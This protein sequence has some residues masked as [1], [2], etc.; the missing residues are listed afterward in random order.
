MNQ[1]VMIPFPGRGHINPMLNLSHLL[2]S[3]INHPNRTTVFT[4][5]V[6]KEWLRLLNPD[7]NQPTVHFAT[8]PNVL[9][10]ELHRGS[11]MIAF[12]TAICTKMKRPF[13][14]VLDRMETEVPVNLIIADANML[15]PFEVANERNIPVAAYWPMPASSGESRIQR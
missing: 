15:W 9:P 4:V 5:I 14:E 7:P 1:V 6:T 3:L 10:S 11:N 8:I 2:S 13:E 12:L